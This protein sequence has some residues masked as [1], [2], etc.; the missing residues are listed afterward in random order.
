MSNSSREQ[1]DFLIQSKE[2]TLSK[3]LQ[4]IAQFVPRGSR[5]ADIGADHAY[6]LIYLA[7]EGG[8]IKGIA[9]EINRG[10]WENAKRQVERNGVTGQIE[11]RLGDGLSV[12]EPDE[13]D[14]IVIA[15]MGGAL[16][17]RILEQGDRKLPRNGRL[18]LQPNTDGDK[19]R[20]WLL[21][22]QWEL[23][24]E[25]LVEEAGQL[26]EIL[27]AEPGDPMRPYHTSTLTMEQKIWVGPLLWKKKDPLLLLKLR[28]EQESLLRIEQALKKGKSQE[29]NRKKE[30]IAE[31]ISEIGRLMQWLKEKS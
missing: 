3:R 19:V 5:V 6:L 15:G 7:I 10:P 1:R 17:S 25:L 28:K 11:V 22:H 31:K 14:V 29:A 9:G 24:D 2:T 16:I 18:I 8:L 26:Y 23:I 20:R 21:D 27:V 12:L 4:A 13:V 30:M